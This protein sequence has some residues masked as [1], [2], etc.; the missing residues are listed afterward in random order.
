M[1]GEPTDNILQKQHFRLVFDRLPGVVLNCTRVRIPG[2]DSGPSFQ[3]TPLRRIA[4]E[5]DQMQDDGPLGIEFKLD[6]N[7][8]AY[9]EVF[10]WMKA[11]RPL[12]DVVANAMPYEDRRSD[13]TVQILNSSLGVNIH[14]NFEEAFPTK[15]SGFDL[16]STVTSVDP[17]MIDCE[18]EYLQHK[19]ELV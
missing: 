8:Q 13:I 17:V 16:D 2:L 19:F 11:M 6:E 7:L 15:L 18:F 14:A 12:E 10:K 9:L 4:H 3:N 5:G 1:A